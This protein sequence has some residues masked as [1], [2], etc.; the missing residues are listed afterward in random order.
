VRASHAENLL[1]AC[2]R[3]A[4]ANNRLGRV[5]EIADGDEAADEEPAMLPP[6]TIAWQPR[7]SLAT[8]C[9]LR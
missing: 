7:I 2:A 4:A 1:I 8:Q 9:R 6:I 3:L 5:I